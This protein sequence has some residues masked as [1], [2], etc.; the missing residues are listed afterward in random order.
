MVATIFLL[1][2]FP[3]FILHRLTTSMYCQCR[4]LYEQLLRQEYDRLTCRKATTQSS[5]FD[6]ISFYTLCLVFPFKNTTLDFLQR[7]ESDEYSRGLSFSIFFKA[8]AI[9]FLIFKGILF[10]H[11]FLLTFSVPDRYLFV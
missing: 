7:F 8:A 3:P 5:S 9:G 10:L 2:P 6:L 11:L 1:H 4:L